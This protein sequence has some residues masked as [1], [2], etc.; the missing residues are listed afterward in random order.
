MFCTTSISEKC[1]YSWYCRFREFKTLFG[2]RSRAK[3]WFKNLT[4]LD[5]YGITFKAVGV[6]DL[7]FQFLFKSGSLAANSNFLSLRLI[8]YYFTIFTFNT[9]CLFQLNLNLISIIKVMFH[10]RIRLVVSF[11]IC[12][13]LPQPKCRCNNW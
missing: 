2:H 5:L 1:L 9:F 7:V 6:F 10:D 13:A 8:E 4:I 3:H 12:H 11:A